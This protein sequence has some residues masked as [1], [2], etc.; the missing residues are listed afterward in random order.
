[1]IR[2]GIKISIDKRASDFIGETD[3]DAS[4]IATIE[5]AY[6]KHNIDKLLQKALELDGYEGGCFIF[7]DTGAKNDELKLPLVIDESSEELKRYRPLKFKVIDPINVFP[8]IYNSSNPLDDNYFDPETYLVLG[9]VVHKSRLIRIVSNEVPLLLKPSYNFLGVPQAQLLWD[10]VAHFNQNRNSVNTLLNKFSLIAFKTN[11]SDVL[12]GALDDDL[13]QRIDYL[14]KKRNNDSILVI[15]KDSEDL[16]NLVTPIGGMTDIVKQSL[17]MLAIVNHMPAVV[18]FG[19]SPSGFNATG[20]SDLINYSNLIEMK[21]IELLK[22]P[23]SV[24]LN[25]I[26]IHDSYC[27]DIINFEFNKFDTS[28]QSIEAMT[29]KTEADTRAVYIQSG[30]LSVEEVRNKVASEKDLGFSFI[31]VDNLP[32]NNV[33]DDLGMT[34]EEENQN[35][36]GN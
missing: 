34:D 16:I 4:H 18:L 23:L 17:E 5:K 7:I 36:I 26:R 21:K 27:T 28:R 12:H 25:A 11:M 8:G 6:Q 10:Y 30:V 32:N 14:A 1:M 9:T 33:G 29:K 13:S 24:I 15:D 19:Q 31:D 35:P 22:E 20:E 2:A 3:T